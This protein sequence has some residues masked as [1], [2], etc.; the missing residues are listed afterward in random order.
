MVC[1]YP[2]V[3]REINAHEVISKTAK[4]SDAFGNQHIR[5]ALDHFELSQG[6][7]NY[8]FP[9]SQASRCYFETLSRHV[10]RKSSHFLRPGI[11]LPGAACFELYS[12]CPGHSCRPNLSFITL[13]PLIYRWRS[14]RPSS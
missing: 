8:H 13:R 2:S 12:P 4:I 3:Q 9:H 7:H 14:V 1:D 5:Q 6:D 10:S 11:D